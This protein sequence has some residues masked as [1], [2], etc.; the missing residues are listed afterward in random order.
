MF[1]MLDKK[2]QGS[3]GSKNMEE[4]TPAFLPQN[5]EDGHTDL[6]T[7]IVGDYSLLK[8]T[9]LAE[10]Y[11]ECERKFSPL[12]QMSDHYTVGEMADA[13]VDAEWEFVKNKHREEVA[14]HELSGKNIVKARMVRIQELKERIPKLHE[15][16]AKRQ[17]RI[18]ALADKHAKYAIR[19]GKRMIQLGLPITA[20]AIVL[21]FFTNTEFVQSIL[22]SNVNMLRIL[23]VCLCLI[24]DASMH[25]LGNLISKKSDS[26]STCMYRTFFAIF[27][28]LFLV[29]VLGSIAIRV[30]SMPLTYGTFDAKGNFVGKQTFTVAE[31]ALAIVSSLATAVTGVLSFFFSVD[32]DY[33]L[34]KE[35]IRL[36]AEQEQD[37]KLC[38]QLE[39]ELASLEQAADPMICDRERR[40]AAEANLEA[41]RKGLK[42]HM[43]KLL[44][45]HQ[46]DAAYADAMT[47]SAQK[48]L[49]NTKTGGV[50]E[51]EKSTDTDEVQKSKKTMIFHEGREY[52]EAV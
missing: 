2:K 25:A 50:I 11:A 36:K 52:K 31:Y 10:R 13:Y 20:M 32:K 5:V 7:F 14:M 47:E 6:S 16:V 37:E 15:K 48:L 33:C 12:V 40:K 34:E 4:Y 29:S 39:A 38:V 24:S 51:T 30:G 45:L 1:H 9:F 44:A 8:D 41:L 3:F 27:M 49:E 46:Q 26:M 43:R 35:C 17:L 19:M 21:D 23:V 28:F 18:D 22:Y 42:I